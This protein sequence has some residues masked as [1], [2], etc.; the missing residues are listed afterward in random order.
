[1]IVV[2][3]V[4]VNGDDL[5][6]SGCVGTNATSGRHVARDGADSSDVRWQGV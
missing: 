1:M 6:L 2:D 3:I 5:G 4:V